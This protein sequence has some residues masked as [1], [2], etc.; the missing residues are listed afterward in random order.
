MSVLPSSTT[1][2]NN[3]RRYLISRGWAKVEHANKRIEILRTKPDDA[4]GYASVAIP[5]SIEFRDA[6][7]LINEAVRLVASYENSP[8][9]QIVDRVL[10]W[11]RDILRARFFKML[12]HEDSLPLEIAADAVSGL[13]EFI[14]YAAY[15]QI[16]PQPFFDKAGAISAEFANHCLFGHTFQGSFGLT[17]ECPLA[18]TPVLPMDGNEPPVPI[19]RQVFERIANGLVTLRDS[20]AKDSIEP[21][22]AGYRTG[23]SANMCR[24]LAELYEKAGGRRIEFDFSWSPQLHTPCERVWKPMVFEGRAYDF[25]RIAATELEKVEIYPDSVIQGRIVILRSEMPPGLDEQAEFEHVI[26]MHWEREKEQTVKIRVPLSPQHYIEACD[27]HKE[28]KAIRIYGVPEK[29]GK[30]WT[31]TK[32]HDFT[33][34]NTK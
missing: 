10:R 27:A 11:D 23:F 29:S 14:G 32:A 17:I 30:F 13:K 7:E 3:L 21:L 12:G 6:G 34:L 1:V 24:T 9:Q 22:L 4:G 8:L 5:S 15:T 16:N 26:T 28:G 31:L 19:E 2:L 20:I 25:A 18:V 33:V